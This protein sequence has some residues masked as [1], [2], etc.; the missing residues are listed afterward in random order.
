[1]HPARRGFEDAVGVAT[2][3][4]EVL[5]EP[6]LFVVS[7]RTVSVERASRNVESSV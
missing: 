3:R 4:C 1:L 2:A 5:G 7:V 6:R